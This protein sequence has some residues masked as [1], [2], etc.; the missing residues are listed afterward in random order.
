VVT[1]R[2][3][4]LPLVEPDLLVVVVV[5]EVVEPVAGLAEPFVEELAVVVVVVA[6]DSDACPEARF[7]AIIS[8][9]ATNSPT[10]AATTRRRSRR[11][12]RARLVFG[13]VC[14]PDSVAASRISSV[15]TR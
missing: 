6:L 8:H 13:E 5:E 11:A 15:R 12:R 3:P 2:R 4:E 1:L 9:A 10:A 14:M 7:T